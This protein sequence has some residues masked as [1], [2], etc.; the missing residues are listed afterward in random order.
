[1]TRR[2][3]LVACALVVSLVST[4]QA[5][6]LTTRWRWKN[7]GPHYYDPDPITTVHECTHGVNSMLRQELG[8]EC[9]YVPVGRVYQLRGS[10]GVT[11]ADVAAANKYRG[12]LVN[13]YLIQQ[14]RYWNDNAL[15]L[16]DEWVAYANGADHAVQWNTPGQHWSDVQYACEMG[17]YCH[18]VLT[19]T[20]KT[21]VD[22]ADLDAFWVWQAERCVLVADRAEKENTHYR[23]TVRPWRE[24]LRA[25]LRERGR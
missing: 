22:Y 20:P 13:L 15:Y 21:Y 17:Y 25:R 7:A 1:M 23:P 5:G 4:S 11:L 19:M 3:V 10:T 9:Y 12:D 16:F 14:Q 24:F 6:W 2:I 18:L 8:G